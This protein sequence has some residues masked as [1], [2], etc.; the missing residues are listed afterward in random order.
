MVLESLVNPWRMEAH[1]G[2]MI[3]IGFAYA[4]IGLWLARW[5]FEGYASLVMVFLTTMAAIPLM[6]NTIKYEE[7]KDLRD[8]QER[9]LIKEHGRALF[10]FLLLFIGSTLAFAFWYA[11][12]P[13]GELNLVFGT[14]TEAI[15][16]IN[17]TPTGTNTGAA[18]SVAEAFKIIFVNN[19]RVLVFCIL[20]SFLYGSGAIFIL[21][22]NASVIGAAVGSFFRRE[23]AAASSLVGAPSLAQYFSS[24]WDSLW[25]YALHGLPEILAYFTAGLAGGIIGIA[26]IRHDFGT[27]KFEHIILDSADLLLLSVALLV[28][29][30]LVEVFVTPLIF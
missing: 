17:R 26:V 25:R 1:P 6:V 27:R 11:V 24:A 14:Q 16:A 4:T 20:F 8:L 9:F 3:G 12:L 19:F 2:K 5:V 15:A 13:S 10:A 22:W 28:A 21:I 18:T 7:T 23:L 30:A 29:S